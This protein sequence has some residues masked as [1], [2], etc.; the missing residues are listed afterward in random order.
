[1]LKA[2]TSNFLKRLS[3]IGL[4]IGLAGSAFIFGQYL[5]PP[6][7]SAPSMLEFRW[8]DDDGYKKLYYY[9][10]SNEK[11]DRATYYFVLKPRNRKT[12]LLKLTIS[13][14]ENFNSDIKPKNLTLCRVQLGSITTKTKCIE[15]IPAVFEINEDQTSIEIYPETPIPKDKEG[16]AVVMKI[17][18]PSRSGMFQLNATGQSP[19]DLPISIYL[20]SWT[21]MVE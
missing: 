21:V 4:G 5:T 7:I 3:N 14:P 6:A 8:D 11:R 9:Q 18:N 12:G 16:Y 2:P 15:D 1:M 20:G 17:F 10:S 13:V 19:G